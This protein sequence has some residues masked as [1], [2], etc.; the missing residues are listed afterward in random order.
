MFLLGT[1]RLSLEKF[2]ESTSYI[3]I[4]ITDGAQYFYY[5][6]LDSRVSLSFRPGENGIPECIYPN[7][8]RIL[9]DLPHNE[10]PRVRA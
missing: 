8:G 7:R 1:F 10:V 9:R 2:N 6:L 3:V 4:Q 5:F